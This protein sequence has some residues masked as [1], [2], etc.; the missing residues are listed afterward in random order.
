MRG[1]ILGIKKTSIL[2]CSFFVAFILFA[3]AT[4]LSVVLL[5]NYY[6]W[7]YFFVFFLG[8][9]ILVKSA[10]FK[11][12]SCCYAGFLLIFVGISGFVALLTPLT[13][14]LSFMFFLSASLASI[15][16]FIFFKQRF[17]LSIAILLFFVTILV[18]LSEFKLIP[19]WISLA[20]LAVGVL[21]FILKYLVFFKRS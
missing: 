14:F 2:A 7:F 11:L 6:L 16:T 20:F 17:Q 12:D 4:T 18:L 3:T 10:L 1:R 5:K 15:I 13:D 21:I 8:G 9:H 19:F